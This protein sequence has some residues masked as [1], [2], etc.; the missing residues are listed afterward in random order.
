MIGKTHKTHIKDAL[1]RL[2]ELTQE[3]ARTSTSQVLN[4]M[5]ISMSRDTNKSVAEPVYSMQTSVHREKHSNTV[6]DGKDAKVAMQE[7]VKDVD[8][9]KCSS[10]PKLISPY[11]KVSSFLA[12]IDTNRRPPCQIRYTG[13]K[14]TTRL[15]CISHRRLMRLLRW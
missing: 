11:G 4:A 14:G 9:A 2:D 7:K 8:E 10:S 5:I 6:I 1:R 12:E 13:G 3:E 15:P